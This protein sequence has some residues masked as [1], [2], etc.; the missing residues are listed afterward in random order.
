NNKKIAMSNNS[1]LEILTVRFN[2]V[3]KGVLLSDIKTC[4][5]NFDQANISEAF[6]ATRNK[7]KE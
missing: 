1:L 3:I 7:Q 6:N 2:D 5:K 4:F